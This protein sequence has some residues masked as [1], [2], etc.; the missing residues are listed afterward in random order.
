VP[1]TDQSLAHRAPLLILSAAV[2]VGLVVVVNKVRL[3]AGGK[4]KLSS[5]IIVV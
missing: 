5:N 3:R 2:L 4:H 1:G